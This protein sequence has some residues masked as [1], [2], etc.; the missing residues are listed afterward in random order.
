MH[1]N[2]SI[3]I[4]VIILIFACS[5]FLIN[6]NKTAISKNIFVLQNL[7]DAHIKVISPALKNESQNKKILK[8]LL[9]KKIS[10]ISFYKTKHKNIEYSI[11]YAKYINPVNLK[12]GADAI[13]KFFKNYNFKYKLTNNKIKQN[14]AIL[15]E[16]TFEKNRKKYAIK[17]QLIK[18]HNILWQVIII[19]QY[20][21]KNNK[22]AQNYINSIDIL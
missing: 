18:K 3:I 17:E 13:I 16:G 5:I 9:N 6:L 2:E 11:V 12:S 19:Y 7:N 21:D 10:E 20:S 22:L 1:K 14:K 8:Y 15:I 4:T